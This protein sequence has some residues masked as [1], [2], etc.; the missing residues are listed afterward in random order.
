MLKTVL[1]AASVAG[2][3]VA[4]LPIHSSTAQAEQMTCRQAAKLHFPADRYSRVAY[5]KACKAAWKAHRLNPQPLPPK[6]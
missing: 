5:R 4:G 3:A 2:L 6:G 1:F